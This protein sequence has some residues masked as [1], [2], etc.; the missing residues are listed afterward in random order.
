MEQSKKRFVIPTSKLG[1]TKP[2]HKFFEDFLDNDLQELETY[3]VD[4][5]NT[6]ESG[7]HPRVKKQ[8][9]E[10]SMFE[11]SGSVTTSMWRDYNVFQFHHPAIRKLF[12]SVAKMTREAS[13]YYGY[14][15]DEQLFMIQGWFNVNY[16]GK[17]KGKL[18][19]HEHSPLGAP[20]F[21]G[22]YSVC[23]EPSETH[24]KINGRE[25]QYKINV[26]KNNRAILSETSHPHAM[27]DW[28][29]DGPRITIAY[30]VL[31]LGLLMMPDQKLSIEQHWVPLS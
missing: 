23:A 8:S 27:G 20:I 31:P 19:W 7:E 17:G 3:L 25:D 2:E 13:E 30:D 28:E 18:D 5:Y 1:V 9:H 14:D 22:Y 10:L 24:Y 4:L 11:D 26:N 6:I 16:V 12:N 21:H 15:F 29:W